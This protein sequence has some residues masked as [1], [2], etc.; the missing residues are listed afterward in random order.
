MGARDPGPA[1]RVSRHRVRRGHRIRFSGTVK[2]VRVGEQIAFQKKSHGRWVTIGGT[3]VHS[4]GH[5]SKRVKIRRGGS[6]RV[7]T[8]VADQQYVSNHGRTVRLHTF[9]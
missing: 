3:V 6:F 9:R 4:G 5:Y 1:T 2:P 7:W 8:G